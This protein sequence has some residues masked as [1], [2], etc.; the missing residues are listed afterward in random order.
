MK[1][2]TSILAV[3]FGVSAVIVGIIGVQGH[4]RH[5]EAVA[6]FLF[7]STVIAYS[8]GLFSR[9]EDGKEG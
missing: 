2:F 1:K 4:H 6:F 9:P 8:F 7:I 3:F 5:L